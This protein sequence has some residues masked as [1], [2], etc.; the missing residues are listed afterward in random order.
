MQ[1]IQ[2]PVSCKFTHRIQAIQTTECRKVFFIYAVF[3]SFAWTNLTQNDTTDYHCHCRRPAACTNIKR[4]GKAH[5]TS[6]GK[7]NCTNIK[8]IGKANC[9]SIGKPCCTHINR[10]GNGRQLLET[11]LP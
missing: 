8:R 6:I 4:N 2:T 3:R 9:T 10:I 5:C 1:A 11:E 7:A